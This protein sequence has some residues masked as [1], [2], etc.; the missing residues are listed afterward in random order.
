MAAADKKGWITN[1]SISNP[2]LV[3]QAAQE[4][5]SDLKMHR[6]EKTIQI[7]PTIIYR[8]P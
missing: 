5:P 8:F 2:L 4:L 7:C 3:I 1:K 6:V